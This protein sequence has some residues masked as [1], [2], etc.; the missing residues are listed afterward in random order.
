MEERTSDWSAKRLSFWEV[1]LCP[2]TINWQ[3]KRIQCNNSNEISCVLGPSCHHVAVSTRYMYGG[4]SV[5]WFIASS[6]Y[7]MAGGCL[8]NK[9]GK[10][11][12]TMLIYC[13]LVASDLHGPTHGPLLVPFGTGTTCS[14]GNISAA[15]PPYLRLAKNYPASKF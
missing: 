2:S 7:S 9:C 12:L 10:C 14:T 11:P 5:A 15:L 1:P 8:S 4:L 13:G 3:G 6:L